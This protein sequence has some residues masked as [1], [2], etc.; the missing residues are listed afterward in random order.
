MRDIVIVGAG[1]FGREVLD[2]FE[3][4][5]RFA[6]GFHNKVIG[7]LDDDVTPGERVLGRLPVLG[8]VDWLS[9]HKRVA[10]VCA[11]GAPEVRAEVVTRMQIEF[12]AAFCNAIHPSTI[13]SPFVEMG[14]GVVIPAGC[15]LTNNITIGNHVHLNIDT[16]VGHDVE[17]EDFV[18]VSPGVHISGRVII[19]TGAYVGTGANIIDRKYIGEWSIVGAGAT[20]VKDV[21][22]NT[23]VVG[24]P[25]KVIKTREKN[26][27]LNG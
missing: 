14:E 1:G 11:I 22:A 23:T 26:W 24:S 10:V 9:N 5:N 2:I 3:D 8:G 13:K 21:P 4:Q 6:D 19:E 7:F 27:Q 18:T 17:I 16:T 20:V 12:D 15:I 25:A